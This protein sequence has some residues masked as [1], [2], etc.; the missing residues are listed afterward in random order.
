M[1][2]GLIKDGGLSIIQSSLFLAGLHKPTK[3]ESD[4]TKKETDHNKR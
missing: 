1:T 2:G 3:K 4:E